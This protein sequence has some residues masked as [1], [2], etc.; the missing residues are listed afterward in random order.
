MAQKDSKLNVEM[1]GVQRKLAAASKHDSTTMKII[2]LLGT[3]FL[4]GAFIAVSDSHHAIL[5]LTLHRSPFSQLHSSTF[6]MPA[7]QSRG[8][9]G[10]TGCSPFRLL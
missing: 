5:L 3:L 1:A 9:F 7:G 8:G 10:F 6:R 4:P 2:S